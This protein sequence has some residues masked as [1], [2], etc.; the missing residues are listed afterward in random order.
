VRSLR[1]SKGMLLD[2]ADPDSVSAGSFFTNP[3]VA[4]TFARSLPQ[5]APRWSMTPDEPDFVAPIEPTVDG[6]TTSAA[7]SDAIAQIDAVAR[8]RAAER[9]E[10]PRLVKLSAAWL[11]EHAGIN[12]GYGLPG[13]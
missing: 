8:Q 9:E 7:T 13:S 4:E 10:K 2:S 3:I 12:K 11:I 1:A 6:E 5:E